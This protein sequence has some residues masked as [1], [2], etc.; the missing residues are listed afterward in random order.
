MKVALP[1]IRLD[2]FA[3]VLVRMNVVT[4]EFFVNGLSSVMI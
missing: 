2:P 4:V 1:G 3:V